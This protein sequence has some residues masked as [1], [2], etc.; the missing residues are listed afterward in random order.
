MTAERLRLRVFKVRS[1]R[2][3]SIVVARRSRGQRRIA[4]ALRARDRRELAGAIRSPGG[5]D[6]VRAVRPRGRPHVAAESA[7]EAGSARV[8]RRRHGANT[9][10]RARGFPAI[11]AE[12][13]SHDLRRGIAHDR[14]QLAA[15]CNLS[16]TRRAPRIDGAPWS[17]RADLLGGTAPPRARRPIIETSRRIATRARDARSS[18]PRAASPPARKESGCQAS[19]R[20]PACP[21]YR[22][23][24]A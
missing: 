20:A 16:S 9:D 10:R 23:V 12:H 19:P 3:C 18:T 6:V 21:I 14:V 1:R 11:P 17:D 4:L 5:L 8:R 13:D 24:G 15:R 22:S 2:G 7:F